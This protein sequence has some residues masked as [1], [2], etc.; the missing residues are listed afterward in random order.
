[1]KI[2]F[3][4]PSLSGTEFVPMR[5]GED[6]VLSEYALTCRGPAKCGD[7]THAVDQGF[8]V[9]G[10]VDGRFEDVAAVWHKEILHALSAG[11]T[12]YGAA[13][14]GALRAAEC[15]PF[16]MIGIGTVFERYAFGGLEDDAAVAQVHAP[17]EFGYVAF[18]EAMVTIDATLDA[19][20]AARAITAEEHGFIRA[21]ADA[22]FFKERTWRRIFNVV[23]P[24]IDGAAERLKPHIRNIKREDAEALLDV[25]LDRNSVAAPELGSDFAGWQFNA[26]S[27]W[28]KLRV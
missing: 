10:L 15:H 23:S 4:G 13:S 24:D 17:A 27:Q 16:G 3:A 19:A 21:K 12:V 22:V 1:M 7:I 5:T 26:T 11:A 28:R 8:R 2:L 6:R 20:F 18:S 25:L 14:M 9:I